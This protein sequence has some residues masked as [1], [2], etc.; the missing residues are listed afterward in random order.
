MI[1]E[2]G[3]IF[4]HNPNI[5]VDR[6]GESCSITTTCPVCANEKT[7]RDVPF[8]WVLEWTNGVLL[9]RSALGRSLSDPSDR[10]R[11]IS[12]LCPKCW[13]TAFA[14]EDDNDEE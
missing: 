12:G 2:K 11:L 10:E 5:T 1:N 14:S 13:D 3:F 7:F 4:N 6:K 9:Q 8:S